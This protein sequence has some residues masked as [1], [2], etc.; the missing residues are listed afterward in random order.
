MNA[1]AR[2]ATVGFGFAFV[3][4]D[5]AKADLADGRLV[6]VLADWCPPFPGYQLYYPRRRQPSAAF[7]LFVEAL[8]YRD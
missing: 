6:R 5:Q 8:R 7:A 3:I 4:E 1:D 2:A